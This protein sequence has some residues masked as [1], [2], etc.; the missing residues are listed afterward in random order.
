VAFV[1]ALAEASGSDLVARYLH[2]GL[3]S[4][5]VVDT[6]QNYLLKEA[7]GLILTEQEKLLAELRRLALLYKYTPAVGRTH[8]VHAEPTSFGLRF[9]GFYAAVLRDRERLE[10]ARK[11]IATAVLSGSVGNYA[12]TPP[13]VEAYVAERLGL[14]P[15]Q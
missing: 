7:L 6:A 8:G 3:T 12:H 14:A 5:D 11:G 10:R 15:V 1:R 9:L 13:E 4:T 2:Y